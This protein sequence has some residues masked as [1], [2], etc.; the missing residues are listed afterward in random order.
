MFKKYTK[1]FEKCFITF[2]G[3][4]LFGCFFFK[5][6]RFISFKISSTLTHV[7]EKLASFSTLNTILLIMEILGCFWYLLIAFSAGSEILDASL[8]YY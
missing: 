8:R 5:S 6:S 2:V 4:S 1:T 3:I 7:I